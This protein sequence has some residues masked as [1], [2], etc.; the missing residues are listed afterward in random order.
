MGELELLGNAA[1]VPIIIAATQLLKKN[2][3][4]RYKADVV[5]FVVALIICPGWWFYNTPEVEI[6]DTFDGSIIQIAK[7]MV[8]MVL[9]SVATWLS[10]TKSYDLFRGNKKREQE[11]QE[12][13]A[14]K[15]ELKTRV[16]VLEDASKQGGVEDGTTQ[17]V[18]ISEKLL[19]ILERRD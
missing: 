13:E 12:I 19:E 10:A 11:K 9:I 16:A 8:D 4:F 2:F 14:E 5:A 18:E 3:S 17:D 6:R 15:E 7:S 1:A